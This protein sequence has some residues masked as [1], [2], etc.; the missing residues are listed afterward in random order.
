RL[1][2]LDAQIPVL[3]AERRKIQRQLRTLK[4]PVLTLP[5]EVTS[6]IFI[7]CLPPA[8]SK[9]TGFDIEHGWMRPLLVGAP[10]VFLH[11]CRAWRDVAIGTPRLW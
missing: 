3:E 1:A 10:L 9:D 6:E 4:F 2:E 8:F 7:C 11:V 5:V